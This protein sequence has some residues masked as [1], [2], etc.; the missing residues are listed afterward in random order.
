MIQ[1]LR[2]VVVALNGEDEIT[3]LPSVVEI[4]DKVNEI[5]NVVN[6]LQEQSNLDELKE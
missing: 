4:V 1:E 6:R 5:I 3:R 2:N